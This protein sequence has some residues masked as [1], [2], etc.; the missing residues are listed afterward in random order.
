MSRKQ[1]KKR[2]RRQRRKG[3]KR[4]DRVK[5]DLVPAPYAGRQV[6]LQKIDDCR[7]RVPKTGPMHVDGVVFADE[8]LLPDLKND[9]ALEQVANVATLPG[10]VGSSLAMP[11]S[12]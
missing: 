10:I 1:R 4:E 12:L 3:A 8:E 2:E 9:R 11:G 7:W 6:P 5:V